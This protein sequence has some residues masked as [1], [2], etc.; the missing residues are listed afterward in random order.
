MSISSMSAM[1]S[2][3]K[4]RKTGATAPPA[5]SSIETA[6]QNA[7]FA[8]NADNYNAGT[9]T[10][11]DLSPNGRN[12]TF[13]GSTSPSVVS[14]SQSAT[15]FTTA[16]TFNVVSGVATDVCNLCPVSLTTY[17]FI[18]VFRLPADP[19]NSGAIYVESGGNW[20]CGGWFNNTGVCSHNGAW[21][22]GTTANKYGFNMW[23]CTDFSTGF[24]R[25]GTALGSAMTTTNMKAG[26]GI[27]TGGA[28]FGGRQFQIAEIL[29]FDRELTTSEMQTIESALCSTY[30]IVSGS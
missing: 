4:P 19:G 13:T 28:T 30:G 22:G 26:S 18:S 6:R 20:I 11:T 27:N 3:T 8:F 14:Y 16:K 24:R 9:K 29:C 25:N 5:I 12:R 17:T 10:F 7:Y 1:S 21:F 15:T 2:Y 23:L